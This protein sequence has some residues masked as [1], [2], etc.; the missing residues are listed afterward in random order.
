MNPHDDQHTIGLEELGIETD[1]GTV[2]HPRPDKAEARNPDGTLRNLDHA[3]VLAHIEKPEARGQVDS[4]R[5]GEPLSAE[6]SL[7]SPG[8]VV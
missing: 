1:P 6:D 8:G 4:V 5:N 3:E 7:E 2:W